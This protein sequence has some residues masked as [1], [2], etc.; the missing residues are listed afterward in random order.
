MCWV[1]Q[2]AIEVF[3][4]GM[5]SV[6]HTLGVGHMLGTHAAHRGP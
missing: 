4:E 6:S 3:V 5:W 2:S 1:M